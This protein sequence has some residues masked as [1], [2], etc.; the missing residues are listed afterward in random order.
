MSI[1]KD[2]SDKGIKDKNSLLQIIY[3]FFTLSASNLREE[4][5]RWSIKGLQIYSYFIFYV[6]YIFVVSIKPV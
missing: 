2:F 5:K 3:Y 4:K 1:S 6:M